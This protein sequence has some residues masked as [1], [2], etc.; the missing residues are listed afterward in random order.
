MRKS[1]L[2]TTL[3]LLSSVASWA[4]C[5]TTVTILD[6]LGGSKTFCTG[7]DGGTGLFS[8]FM[9][10]DGTAGAN[11]A[12]INA[13]GQLAIQAPPTLPLPSGAAL[14]AGN[15]ATLAGA[16]TSSVVQSNTKQVNGVTA[17]VGAGAVGT[18]AQR[19]AI[20]T[21]TATIAGSAP[22]TAGTA[23]AQVVSIQGI[24]SMTK[25]LV[26]PDANA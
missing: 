4:A 16:I 26:T 9:L 22:G 19:V 18:G 24:A 20:G 1:L 3:L 23:S 5:P 11:L 12:A 7:T 21:D 14:E 17:L 8:K 10:A 15:L 13:S 6:G 25:V 2:A